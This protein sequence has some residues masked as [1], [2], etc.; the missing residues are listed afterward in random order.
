MILIVVALLLGSTGIYL[1]AREIAPFDFS[2][3]PSG[4]ILSRLAQES[5]PVSLSIAGVNVSLQTCERAMSGLGFRL[6]PNQ[7]IGA[8]AAN[9]A[10]AAR[11]ATEAMPSLSYGHYIEAMALFVLGR[12][13]EAGAALTR[14]Q[15]VGA[16]EQWIAERRV[17]LAE[18]HYEVLEADVQA[19]HLTDLA[20]LAQSQHG[21][22][23][24][25][26]RYVSDP[27]FRGR[28]TGVVE[29]LPE[30]IQARFVSVVQAEVRGVGG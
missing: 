24:I 17:S 27:D 2:F 12:S 21:I 8:V 23:S 5:P 15:L 29:T 9:C 1:A 7:T 30:D 19:A 28:V 18:S 26:A 3:A 11:K 6:S 13:D 16:N 10:Q 25:A 22:R 14:S 4:E 20:L